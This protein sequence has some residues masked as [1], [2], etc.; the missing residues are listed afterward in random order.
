MFLFTASESLFMISM[1]MSYFFS[2]QTYSIDDFNPNGAEKKNCDVVVGVTMTEVVKEVT[3]SMTGI[4]ITKLLGCLR[5][6][7]ALE[8][9]AQRIE[10]MSGRLP[11]AEGARKKFDKPS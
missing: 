6:Y 1:A 2:Y 10:L 9:I 8:P 7:S 5:G 11:D 4:S 3:G